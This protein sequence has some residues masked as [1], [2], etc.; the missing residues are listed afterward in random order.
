MYC[1]PGNERKFEVE[2]R[3]RRNFLHRSKERPIGVWTVE[4]SPT[5]TLGEDVVSIL[6]TLGPMLQKCVEEIERA[7]VG[8]PQP[9]ASMADTQAAFDQVKLLLPMKL[10]AESRAAL[11]KMDAE[12]VFGELYSMNNPPPFV[13]STLKAIMVLLG[14]PRKQ[15]KTWGDM[16]P[17]CTLTLLDE[18]LEL[19]LMSDTVKMRKRWADS[20]RVTE[21][22]NAKFTAHAEEISSS[23]QQTGQSVPTQ[24]L[25]KWLETT[26]MIHHIALKSTEDHAYEHEKDIHR[27]NAHVVVHSDLKKA[28]K[29]VNVANKA[30]RPKPSKF[31]THSPQKLAAHRRV[32]KHHEDHE[33]HGVEDGEHTYATLKS[34]VKE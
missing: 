2:L 30:N 22:M 13:F 32:E 17:H 20:M 11:R 28:D 24:L 19:D 5:T 27:E 6:H 33:D 7:R 3:W 15:L 25:L 1:P 23:R 26:R 18:M 34:L 9:F 14:H 12:A 16:R 31:T 10:Q 8:D 29:S 4:L 21:A